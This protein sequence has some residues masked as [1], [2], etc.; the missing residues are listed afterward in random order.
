MVKWHIVDMHIAQVQ[1]YY[2]PVQQTL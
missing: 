2:I 1:T